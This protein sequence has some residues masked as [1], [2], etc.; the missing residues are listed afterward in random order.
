LRCIDT[1][2]IGNGIDHIE[3]EQLAIIVQVDGLAPPENVARTDIYM[4]ADADIPTPQ[5]E[6]TM[7]Y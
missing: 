6:N 7:R 4:G 2:V 5:K 1:V 3:T